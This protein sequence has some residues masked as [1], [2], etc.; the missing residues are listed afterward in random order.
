MNSYFF[1]LDDLEASIDMKKKQSFN[2]LIIFI[3]KQIQISALLVGRV[4]R[5]MNGK[6]QW[7]DTELLWFS[8]KWEKHNNAAFMK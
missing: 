2:S 8:A 1:L 4:V 6:C 5:S 7:L 3:K